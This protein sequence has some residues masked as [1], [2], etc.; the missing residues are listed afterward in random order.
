M[1]ESPVSLAP[2]SFSSVHVLSSPHSDDAHRARVANDVVQAHGLPGLLT[3][4]HSQ[5]LFAPTERFDGEMT[6]ATRWWLAPGNAF[7][8]RVQQ[9]LASLSLT[10][11]V[12]M[13][14]HT[15]LALQ[16]PADYQAPYLPDERRDWSRTDAETVRTVAKVFFPQYPSLQ[17]PTCPL[18]L[19]T[20]DH[21]DTNIGLD[22]YDDLKIYPVHNA[23]L[24][25]FRHDICAMHY[26][27]RA[28]SSD[29]VG[30]DYLNADQI[31]ALE[32]TLPDWDLYEEM[33]MTPEE[34][35]HVAKNRL[36]PAVDVFPSL[37]T[38]DNP[39]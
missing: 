20:Y 31:Q 9:A 22:E 5:E 10:S 15:L 11:A 17:E 25:A 14:A 12:Q 18:Y 7:A 34:S 23:P 26:L 35:Y 6:P 8:H 32:R 36:H 30:W 38:L 29:M 16:P 13:L 4:W 28:H 19:R 39:R 2:I 37:F 27:L 3:L 33:G 21:G 24:H 1:L